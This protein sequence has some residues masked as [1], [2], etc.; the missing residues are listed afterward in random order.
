MD[1]RQSLNGLHSEENGWGAAGGKGAR[2][3]ACRMQIAECRRR[4][5]LGGGFAATTAFVNGRAE[6]MSDLKEYQMGLG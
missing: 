4:R 6:L 1:Q 2:G 5:A 3:L